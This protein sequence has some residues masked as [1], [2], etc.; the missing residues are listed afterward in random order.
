MFQLGSQISNFFLFERLDIKKVLS[1]YVCLLLHSVL[2]SKQTNFG[3]GP[4]DLYL[5]HFDGSKEGLITIT[6]LRTNNY[7]CNNNN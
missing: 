7:Y 4:F 5:L 6:L 1:W 2:R 3:N